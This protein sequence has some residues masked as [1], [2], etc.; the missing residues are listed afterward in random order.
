MG[1]LIGIWLVLG[2]GHASPVATAG[3][4]QSYLHS[5]TAG[6]RGSAIAIH[7]AT[8]EILAAW[9]LEGAVN[10]AYPPGSTAKVV[11]STAAL[12]D[13]RVTPDEHLMCR[14]VPPLV[15]SFY[16]CTHPPAP[17]GFTISSAL[18][19]SCNFFFAS[20]SLRETPEAL[21][22][23]YSVFGFGEAAM[24]NGK[25]TGAGML[26]KPSAGRGLAMAALGAGDVAATAAQLLDAYTLIANQGTE[27]GLW[28]RPGT[29]QRPRPRRRIE[30]KESTYAALRKGLVGGVAYGTGQ[31]AAVPE[32]RWREKPGPPARSTGV[33]PPMPGSSDSLPPSGPRLPWW[34]FWSEETGP[35]TRRRWR[36]NCYG[37]TLG[38]RESSV[39][40]HAIVC[41]ERPGRNP[42]TRPAPADDSAGCGPPSPPRGRGAISTVR[43]GGTLE[44]GGETPRDCHP[45]Q[46]RRIWH[47]LEN[48]QGEI[49]R[50]CAG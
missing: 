26:R 21:L 23:W 22:H 8:G 1:V 15:G 24:L 10:D 45:E 28:T 3:S 40:S 9:N 46:Q 42:L 43:W 2:L 27:Y 4:L 5:L 18:A 31:A 50:C 30:L 13:G 41:N 29:R 44:G 48:T 20:L 39:V 16:T 33:A 37:T 14:R 17:E 47:C 38:G 19:N 32:W 12:E 34:C 36:G 25:P 6:R 35:T 7:P 11:I 49:L